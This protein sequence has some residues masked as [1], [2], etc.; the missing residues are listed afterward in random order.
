MTFNFSKE[1]EE[2]IGLLELMLALAIIALL[3]V[4]AMR[5]WGTTKRSSDY[6]AA[7]TD[8]GHLIAGIQTW[9]G[10][11]TDY[12]NLSLSSLAAIKAIPGDINPATG[13]LP[14]WDNCTSGKLSVAPNSGNVQLADV[15]FSGISSAV[16]VAL[17]GR[18]NNSDNSMV[19][20]STK[21]AACGP[22]ACGATFTATI[23]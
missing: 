12:T 21:A 20:T 18:V 7:T 2:G 5:F 4:M 10:N 6:N 19:N 23:N 11:A 16:C 13:A 15:S 8:M 14:A 1:R 17:A 3:L 22:A 9:K